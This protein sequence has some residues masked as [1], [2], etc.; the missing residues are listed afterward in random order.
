MGCF[1]SVKAKCFSCGKKHVLQSKGG[2]CKGK[3]YYNDSVPIADAAYVNGEH[4]ECEACGA[5]NIVKVS[6][7][8][9]AI[10]TQPPE[11]DDDD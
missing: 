4:F 5:K 8:R 1:N 9:V 10:L 3:T 7:Q 2:T 6:T 11:A